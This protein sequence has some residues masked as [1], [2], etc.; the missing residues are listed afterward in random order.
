MRKILRAAAKGLTVFLWVAKG[1]LLILAV[2][3]VVMWPV[4]CG[5]GMGVRAERYTAG[6]ASGEDHIYYAACWD[7][8][9]VLGGWWQDAGGGP[10]LAGIRAHVASGGDGWRWQRGSN[11]YNW[12]E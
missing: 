6:P 3:A 4:S 8:R 11:G 9:A 5:R 2:G 1:L 10:W 7:G 12:D